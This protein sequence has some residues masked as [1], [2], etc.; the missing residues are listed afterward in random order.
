M[1]GTAAGVAWL[2]AL[3]FPVRLMLVLS[4][5]MLPLL[6]YFETREDIELE[7]LSTADLPC[8]VTRY[9]ADL[10]RLRPTCIAVASPLFECNSS[11]A[12]A[13]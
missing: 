6:L 7:T 4:C 11:A 12:L 5:W 10:T 13:V 3:G 2:A 9:Q 1:E 8:T